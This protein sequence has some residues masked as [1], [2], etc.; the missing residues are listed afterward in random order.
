MN[1]KTVFILLIEFLFKN[2]NL[3]WFSEIKKSSKFIWESGQQY[4]FQ[5]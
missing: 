2:L 4:V 3:K 1:D 5:F